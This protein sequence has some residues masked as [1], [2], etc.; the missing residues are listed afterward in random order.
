MQT[1]CHS[2]QLLLCEPSLPGSSSSQRPPEPVD[3]AT[4]RGACGVQPVTLGR[5]LL[6]VQV[7][8]ELRKRGGPER[9]VFLTHVRLQPTHT[10]ENEV[11]SCS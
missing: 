4:V 2:G 3:S 9:L 8:Q 7:A 10:S 11:H 6:S 1:G 5:P